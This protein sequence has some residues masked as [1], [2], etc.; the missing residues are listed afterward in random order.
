VVPPDEE[1]AAQL[2]AEN[3]VLLAI[4]PTDPPATWTTIGLD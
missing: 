1:L 2:I 3:R 4:S